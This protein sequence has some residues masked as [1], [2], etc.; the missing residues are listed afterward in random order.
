MVRLLPDVRFAVRNLRR[1]PLFTSV[2]IASLALGIG[3]NTAIFTLIDQLMLRLLPVKDPE[4][5]A[6]LWTTGPHMGSN[7]GSRAMSYPMYQDFQQKAAPF[8]QVFCRYNTATSILFDGRTERVTAELVSGNY[9]QA[10]G[11]P[12]AIGRV[13]HSEQDDRVYKG[14]PSVVL[15]YQYWTTRFASDPGVVGRKI[16]V[17]NYPMTIVGVSAAGFRG[18]DPSTS[19]QIRVPIQMKA[20]MTPGWDAMGDR[21][22]Q[23]LQVFARCKPGFTIESAAAPLQPLLAQILQEELNTPKLRE[24]S[25]YFRER[26]LKRQVQLEQVGTGY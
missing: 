8:S 15:S 19:P 23:W 11:V 24:I 2:A 13:F 1:S 17:N 12:A 4:Q 5:L 22:Y 3:V 9:F 18:L 25:P 26:F 16:I 10:L 7:R 6:M 20:L 21:R 14:H